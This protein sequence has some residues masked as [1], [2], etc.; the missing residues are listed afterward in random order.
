MSL[1]NTL[2]TSAAI[3]VLG[4][5]LAMADPALIYDLGGKFDK[6]FNEAAYMG[7]QRWVEETGG[8]YRE[9]EMQS[10]AQREQALRR[11]AESGS[12]PIVMAGF[13]FGDVLG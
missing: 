9:L 12:N 1:K 2:L 4:A 3:S 6:S 5:G 11:L 10:E 7:A 8:T 13:A